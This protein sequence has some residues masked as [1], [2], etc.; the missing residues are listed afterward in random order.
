MEVA[1]DE[2]WASAEMLIGVKYRRAVVVR[3]GAVEGWGGGEVSQ[4]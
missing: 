3:H 1:V 2:F 4:G